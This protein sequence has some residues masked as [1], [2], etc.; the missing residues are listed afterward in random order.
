MAWVVDT[1]VLLDIHLADPTFA[2]RSGR[3]LALHL[4]DGLVICPVSYV[5][6]APAFNGDSGLQ[7]A[8]LQEVGVDWLQPWT[9]LDTATS[10]QLWAD[11]IADRRLGHGSKRPVADVL[12]EGFA[13]RFQGIITRNQ[14]HFRSVPTV[15]P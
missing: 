8:F 14:K 1:S 5:E 3:C 6:L 2:E 7:Q 11:H 15:V 4:S 10:H 13:H 12:I 9:S